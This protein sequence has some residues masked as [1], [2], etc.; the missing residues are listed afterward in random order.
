[1]ST[2]VDAV[3][4]ALGRLRS[5]VA[6]AAALAAALALLAAGVFVLDS[7]TRADRADL[8][9]SLQVRARQAAAVGRQAFAL[10]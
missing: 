10:P 9:R 1:M 4:V 5:R 7:A 6:L 8:D 3:R 2:P